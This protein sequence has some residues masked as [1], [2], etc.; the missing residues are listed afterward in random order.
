M[1]ELEIPEAI[2]NWLDSDEFNNAVDKFCEAFAVNDEGRTKTIDGL[3]KFV[4]KK[5]NLSELVLRLAQVVRDADK[6]VNVKKFLYDN[7]LSPIESYLWLI[8]IDLLEIGG[9]ER[10]EKKIRELKALEDSAL[11]EDNKKPEL[12]IEKN[13]IAPENVPVV[14][15]VVPMPSLKNDGA[16]VMLHE[17]KEEV[18]GTE[19]KYNT[20]NVNQGVVKSFSSNPPTSFGANQDKKQPVKASISGLGMRVVHY[21]GLMTP[22]TQATLVAHH[23]NFGNLST[24][25]EAKG[26]VSEEKQMKIPKP[27][28]KW[29]R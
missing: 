3:V 26:V 7:F 29:F 17:F 6:G 9:K 1:E 16:P 4:N 11:D 15:V 24:M 18:R 20:S 12:E 23:Q 27:Q 14:Q 22:I 28:S 8:N 21:N 13:V 19:T 5:I 10:D 2:Y 25:L